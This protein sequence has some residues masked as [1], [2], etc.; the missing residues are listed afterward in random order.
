MSASTRSARRQAVRAVRADRENAEIVHAV[1][2]MAIRRLDIFEWVI[3]LVGALLASLGGAVV[4]W[5]RAATA[6]W[7]FRSTWIGASLLLFIVPGAISVARIKREERAHA[8]LKES[9]RIGD[10]G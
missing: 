6:G 9:E 5:L 3:F 8:L 10:D 1:A 2:Q 7:D 4:A